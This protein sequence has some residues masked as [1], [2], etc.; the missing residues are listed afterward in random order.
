[1][2]WLSV[3]EAKAHVV[4]DEVACNRTRAELD[5]SSLIGCFIS[6]RFVLVED[7]LPQLFILD[8]FEFS[9]LVEHPGVGRAGVEDASNFLRRVPNVEFAQVDHVLEIGSL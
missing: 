5:L 8:V 3:T 7:W 2:L 1:M 6:A 9:V 4:S